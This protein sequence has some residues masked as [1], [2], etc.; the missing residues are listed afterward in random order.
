MC[1]DLSRRV[2]STLEVEMVFPEPLSPISARVSPCSVARHG[3]HENGE[4]TR[5][6]PEHHGE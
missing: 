6:D 2:G 5:A 1:E 3:A 4:H